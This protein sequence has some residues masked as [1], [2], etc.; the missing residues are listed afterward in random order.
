MFCL[1]SAEVTHFVIVLTLIRVE[2]F[3]HVAAVFTYVLM[4]VFIYDGA[5]RIPNGVITF[6]LAAFNFYE[7]ENV[8]AIFTVRVKEHVKDPSGACD[9]GY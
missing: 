9:Y 8:F 5:L 3:A 4:L 6:R 2:F 1:F 7:C